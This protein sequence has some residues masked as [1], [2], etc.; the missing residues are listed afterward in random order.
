MQHAVDDVRRS[1]GRQGR[2]QEG[3][4]DGPTELAIGVEEPRGP[5]H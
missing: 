2:G 3:D 5:A 4:P 1:D